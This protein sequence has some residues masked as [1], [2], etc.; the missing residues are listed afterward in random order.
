MPIQPVSLT[1]SN[2]G[3]SSKPNSDHGVLTCR[4]SQHAASE[5]WVCVALVSLQIDESLDPL[6]VY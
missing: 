2:L 1:D 4:E 5:G 3:Q 6:L